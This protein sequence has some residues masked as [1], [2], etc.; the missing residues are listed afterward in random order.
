[1]KAIKIIKENYD[2]RYPLF[3]GNLQLEDYS[4]RFMPASV[5]LTIDL[6]AKEAK[7][8]DWGAYVPKS[9]TYTA[10]ELEGRICRFFA[11]IRFISRRNLAA[12]LLSIRPLIK[13]AFKYNEIDGM[14][15]DIQNLLDNEFY[16]CC[17]AERE[18]VDRQCQAACEE[19]NL[20][21]K[22]TPAWIRKNLT[23]DEEKDAV[24]L[25]L[26]AASAGTQA[27]TDIIRQECSNEIWNAI[28]A[29]QEEE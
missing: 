12:L 27:D 15:N 8:E 24:E 11:Q 5:C 7:I 22:L 4:G 26:R 1:M 17:D 18:E 28:K 23:E 9:S 2:A 16:D 25:F 19:I 10:R 20:P 21:E 6:D 14:E 29:A 13:E 3:D